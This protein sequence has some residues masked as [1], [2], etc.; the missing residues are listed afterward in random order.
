M[1]VHVLFFASLREAAATDALDVELPPA[2]TLKDLCAMLV[3]QLGP[4]AAAALGDDEVR[5]AVN[6]ELVQ[7]MG[8]AL[9]AGDEVAFL[10]PV[11]GG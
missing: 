4:A 11:T 7:G 9:K 6:Q 8:A 5:V 2:A 1:K 3:R 10:P